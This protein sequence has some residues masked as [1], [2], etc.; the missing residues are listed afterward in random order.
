V[1]SLALV[2][3]AALVLVVESRFR[4]RARYH[5]SSPGAART[6]AP[7]ALGA[8]RWPALAFCSLVVG[9]FLVLPLAVL[10]Y[11]VWQAGRFEVPW[12]QALN[13]LVASGLAAGIAAV[14]VLPVAFVSQRHPA[15]WTR[16]L[17][18]A[19]Y[20]A[21]ALP[22]IVIALSLVFFGAR[23]GGVLYQTLGMLVFAYVVRFAPQALAST[24]AAL[25][26]VDPRVE[27]A[28]RGLGRGPVYVLARVTAPLIRP[29]VLAGAALVFL[30]AM[31]ELPATLLLRPIGFDTLATEIWTA[32]SVA[33]YSEAA[34][35]ALLLVLVSAPFVYALAARRGADVG[36][37][38]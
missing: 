17:E 5:R 2:S 6:A 38:D 24:S 22:G 4:R 1:L 31:K 10:V 36:P 18:R 28:A 37:V 35:A 12:D 26:T 19:S 8:W 32:T 13:S 9:A 15:P 14:A 34:P 11:W 25:R 23:Y 29:G 7:A 21:N 33:A 16:A 3:L 27:E 30:S 20:T